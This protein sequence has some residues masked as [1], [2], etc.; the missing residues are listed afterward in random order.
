MM[1]KALRLRNH[2]WSAVDGTS[3][4]NPFPVKPPGKSPQQPRLPMDAALVSYAGPEQDDVDENLQ[5]VA[6]RDSGGPQQNTS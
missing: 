1:V 2:E 4:S 5:N 3:A 6:G